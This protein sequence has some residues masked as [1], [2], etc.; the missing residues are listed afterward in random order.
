MKGSL[1]KGDIDHLQTVITDLEGQKN[2]LQLYIQH[3]RGK[4]IDKTEEQNFQV[5]EMK[6]SIALTLQDGQMVLD[7]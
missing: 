3:Q 7:L 4:H 6:R 2:S 1:L 5:L